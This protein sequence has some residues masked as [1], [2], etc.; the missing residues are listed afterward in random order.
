MWPIHT[1]VVTL[2]K[3]QATQDERLNFSPYET[4]LKI[5]SYLKITKVL[6]YQ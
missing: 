1:L 4:L 6:W 3:A 2:G 5:T